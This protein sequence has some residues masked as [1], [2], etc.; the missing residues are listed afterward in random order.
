ME[1]TQSV[2]ENDRPSLLQTVVEDTCYPPTQTS[3]IRAVKSESETQRFAAL[4]ELARIYWYPVFAT[5]RRRGCSPRDAEDLTQELFLRLIRNNAFATISKDRG[6]LRAYLRTSVR[7]LCQEK[8]RREHA[9][10]RIP[11]SNLLSIDA[12]EGEARYVRDKP[13]NNEAPDKFFDERWA[14][15]LLKEV[16]NRLAAEFAVGPMKERFEALRPYIIND[17]STIGYA[18]IASRLCV[19]PGTLK[20][21]MTRFR[22]RFREALREEIANTLCKEA[23][24]D[25]ELRHL[26]AVF[27]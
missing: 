9:G 6:K 7:R 19:S 25:E 11:E 21:T 18:G 1:T 20:T 27:G 4:S 13:R 16:E 22:S 26:L 10:K 5:A 14:L 23:D 24:V 2:Q 15:A 17:S 3:L 12:E 8:H